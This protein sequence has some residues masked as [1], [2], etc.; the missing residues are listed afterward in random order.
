M[1]QTVAVIGSLNYDIMFNVKRLP[2][3]GETMVA[4]GAVIAPGGK[5][6]NQAVQA[7]KLGLKTY[8]LGAV[9]RDSMGDYLLGEAKRYG[10]DISHVKRSEQMTGMAGVNVLED[11][12]VYAVINR[13][14]NYDLT[15]DDIDAME[16]L[17]NE[18][19]VVILQNEIPTEINEYVIDKA[20]ESGTVIL[21]NA[22][23]DREVRKEYLEKCDIIIVNEVE[24]SY[25]LGKEIKTV[26]NAVNEGLRISNEMGNQ[27]IVTLGSQGSV[28]CAGGRA[29]IVEPKK[30]HAVE[31]TGAGDSYIG[32]LA[33]GLIHDMDLFEAARF[34]TKCSAVTVC[35]MGAQPSMPYLNQIEE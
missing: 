20:K 6:A 34:A 9:G 28:I 18:A 17:L 32:G 22:A 7:A 8:M 15:K 5:G 12:S 27:W 33:Y 30:V 16:E 4:E 3:L 1:N 11:G 13:G 19:S 21:Y 26:S 35:G 31:T 25:Y 2:K 10:V 14:A 29:E 24:A 23:P